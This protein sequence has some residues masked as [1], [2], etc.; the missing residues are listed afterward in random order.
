MPAKDMF[1][2]QV[3]EVIDFI[4]KGDVLT[5]T[6]RAAVESIHVATQLPEESHG[7]M[8]EIH[9][10]NHLFTDLQEALE[11]Y[12]DEDVE[13]PYY[14]L[15]DITAE[16]LG[17]IPAA[18]DDEQRQLQR[19]LIEYEEEHDFYRLIKER[20][21]PLATELH[22]ESEHVDQVADIISGDLYH[23]ATARL[24]MKQPHPYFEQMFHIYRNQGMPVGWVGS[25]LPDEGKFVIYA[26]RVESN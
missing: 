9:T 11:F 19:A 1:P 26:Q 4:E 5:G 25:E 22:I 10:S 15:L 21:T 16:A 13:P 3:Q 8:I 20:M 17:D 12:R 18:T 23:C 7:K 2:P 14:F 6:Y 24:L